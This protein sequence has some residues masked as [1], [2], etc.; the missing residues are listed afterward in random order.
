MRVHLILH[1]IVSIDS[2]TVRARKK[3]T[4]QSPKN[5]LQKTP[6]LDTD[7]SPADGAA[8]PTSND[9]S[10]C[11]LTLIPRVRRKRLRKRIF[12]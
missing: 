1:G 11:K 9:K 7:E 10:L 5:Q 6:R 12:L 2:A 8:P 3:L 4:F